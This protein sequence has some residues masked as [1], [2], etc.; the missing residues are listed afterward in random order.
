MFF[1]TVVLALSVIG[2]PLFGGLDLKKESEAGGDI[3]A[4]KDLCAKKAKWIM[5][6]T[7]NNSDS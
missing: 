5:F 4:F 1:L 6:Y 7:K 2:V 3:M